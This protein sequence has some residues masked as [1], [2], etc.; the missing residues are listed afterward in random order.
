[1]HTMRAPPRPLPVHPRAA[2]FAAFIARLDTLPHLAEGDV[3]VLF[4]ITVSDLVCARVW[5]YFSAYARAHVCASPHLRAVN[6]REVWWSS[7]QV[8]QSLG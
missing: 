1:M 4:E 3:H 5:W 8:N 6:R 2:A 7:G